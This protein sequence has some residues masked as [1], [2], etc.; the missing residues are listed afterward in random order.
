MTWRYQCFNK[1]DDND[2]FFVHQAGIDLVVQLEDRQAAA[3]KSS[4]PVARQRV[5]DAAKDLS[6]HLLS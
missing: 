3:S 6:I 4:P 5:N 1:T 2:A